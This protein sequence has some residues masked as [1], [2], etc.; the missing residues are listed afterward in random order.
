MEGTPYTLAKWRVA[1][2]KAEEFVAAWRD[3]G[4]VFSRLPKPPIEGTLVQSTT[5]PQLYY[6]FGPWRS[7]EDVAAMRTDPEAQTALA[8]LR[9]LCEEATPGSY[10]VV[11]HVT[12]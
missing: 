12:V 6:S 3:L 1:P 11:L 4:E 8:R 10:Q 7:A 2:G 9:A 5:D